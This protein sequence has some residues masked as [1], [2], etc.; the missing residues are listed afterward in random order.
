MVKDTR[1][2][3]IESAEASLASGLEEN[4]SF[5]SLPLGIF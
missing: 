1:I 5:R 2:V 3:S 4:M